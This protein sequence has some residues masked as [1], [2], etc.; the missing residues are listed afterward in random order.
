MTTVAT[1]PNPICIAPANPDAAPARSG[2]TETAPASALAERQ[3]V[4]E[5][6]RIHRQEQRERVVPAGE[7]GEEHADHRKERDDASRHHERE[8]ADA[9]G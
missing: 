5:A 7:E 9:A 2:R 1:P 8:D 4:G 3:P 6:D